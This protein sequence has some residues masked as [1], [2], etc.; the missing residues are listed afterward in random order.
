MPISISNRKPS[1]S[2]SF[3]QGQHPLLS[4][5]PETG[6]P[7][8]CFE[9]HATRFD[10]DVTLQIEIVDSQNR[11]IYSTTR[12][13]DSSGNMGTIRWLSFPSL[14]KGEYQFI[15]KGACNGRSQDSTKYFMLL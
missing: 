10:A 7:G 15:A 3:G 6:S 13:T 12:K 9:L 8:E 2:V 4:I 14:P 11:L 1:H 5:H